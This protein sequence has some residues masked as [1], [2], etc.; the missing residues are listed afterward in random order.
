MS[1][2]TLYVYAIIPG[3]SPAPTITGIDG[4]P[5]H[6][7]DAD[8]VSAVVHTH[9]SSPYEGPDDDVKRWVLEHSDVIDQCWNQAPSV[10]PV[11]FN[12]IARGSE[13]SGATATD[14]LRRWLQDTGEE[15]MQRLNDLA[16]TSELRVEI[17]LD[18]DHFSQNEPEVTALKADLEGK[19]PGVRRLLEKRLQKVQK[20]LTETAADRLY[21]E[22]RSRIAAQCQQL[23]D[24]ATTQRPEGAV[25]VLT[26]ACLVDSA[27]T[28]QLG[29]ELTQ[30]QEETP[31]AQI[32]FL[33]PWPPYSFVDIDAGLVTAQGQTGSV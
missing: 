4:S 30:I 31:S 15:L 6:T 18:T 13:E 12:V 14:Q 5:L 23:Q 8:L 19:A 20:Q 28:S 24:Y 22:Y 16:G 10:L 7:V 32:R 11:S 21:P 2:A 9:H 27:H 33:G 29:A 25:S 26:A 1:G 3:G 17:N